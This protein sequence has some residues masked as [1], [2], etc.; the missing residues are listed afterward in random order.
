MADLLGLD[1]P[2]FLRPADQRERDAAGNAQRRLESS[3]HARWLALAQASGDDWWTRLLSS[4]IRRAAER[5]ANQDAGSQAPS[6]LVGRLAFM[7]FAQLFRSTFPAEFA[8]VFRGS[9][10][11]VSWILHT[12]DAAVGCSQ[13]CGRPSRETVP[14]L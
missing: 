9:P 3:L 6:S 14:G 7:E 12:L 10:D 11:R 5:F 4:R 1:L 8:E 13:R 2:T